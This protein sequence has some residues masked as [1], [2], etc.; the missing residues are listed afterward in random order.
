MEQGRE[1]P[2]KFQENWKRQTGNREFNST[3]SERNS[4]GEKAQSP[5]FPGRR[6]WRKKS[7]GRD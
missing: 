3:E 1:A 4:T 2:V 5:S 7:N 6:R